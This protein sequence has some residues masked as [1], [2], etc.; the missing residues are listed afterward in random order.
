MAQLAET[1]VHLRP[2]E[3]T[4]ESIHRLGL[5][6]QESAIE[7]ARTIYRGNVT[8]EIELEE[9]SAKLRAKLAGALTAL[10]LIYM[11]VGNYKA[12]F[13]SLDLLCDHA[14]KFG[15]MV[16]DAFTKQASAKPQQV[17]R[18]ERRLK[19]PGKIK[20]LMTT[21]EGLQEGNLSAAEMNAQL[22]KIRSEIEQ[23]EKDLSAEEKSGFHT[24]LLEFES[25][26][27]FKGLPHP[28]TAP[29]IPRVAIRPEYRAVSVGAY[30]IVGYAPQFDGPILQLKTGPLEFHKSVF[31]P[32]IDG[33]EEKGK[34][35]G[36]PILI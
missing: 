16:S 24:M 20:R 11:G 14:R 27:P 17:Y 28:L 1:Y 31:V 2:Y 30:P 35:Q 13:D 15:D 5:S 7:A 6:A 9:G 26:A 25:A 22:E 12:L 34:D 3:L 18:V 33:G 8:V 10:N 32:P 29:S 21:L 19:T 23:I 36:Q 4:A